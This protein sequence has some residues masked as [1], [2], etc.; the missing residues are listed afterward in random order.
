MKYNKQITG[1]S[2]EY[3]VAAELLKRNY[4]VAITMG[5]AKA[6]DLY[7]TDEETEKTYSI[8]V[9]TLRKKPNCF[10][11][12]TRKI[13]EDT[14]YFFVYLNPIERPPEYYIVTGRELLAQKKHF[15]GASL[16][17]RDGRETVNHGPL[18]EHFEAW[19]KLK[20]V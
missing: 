17:R 10:T 12:H 16:G 7:A 4:Q 5:N 8:Q 1:L 19:D 20:S 13:R 3:F 15:Y 2:G 6:I 18:R 14:V 9:K 11:L